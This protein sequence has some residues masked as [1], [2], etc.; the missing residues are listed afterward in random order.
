M[1][2]SAGGYRG[3]RLC[4]GYPGS[5][6]CERMALGLP[7]LQLHRRRYARTIVESRASNREKLELRHANRSVGRQSAPRIRDPNMPRSH[8]SDTDGA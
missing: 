3:P 1:P 4:G 7:V 6:P 8:E 2:A 5:G